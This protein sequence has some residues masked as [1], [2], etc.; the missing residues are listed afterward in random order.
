MEC[1][2]VD[3]GS[4]CRSVPGV[5]TVFSIDGDEIVPEPDGYLFT[6]RE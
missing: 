4:Y 2:Q 1:T 3:V 5:K 6:Q